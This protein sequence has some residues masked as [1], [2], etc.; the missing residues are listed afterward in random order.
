[1]CYTIV[2]NFMWINYHWGDQGQ[3]REISSEG[4]YTKTE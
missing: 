3:D 2:S 4:S 1:M